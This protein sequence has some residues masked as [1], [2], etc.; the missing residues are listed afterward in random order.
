M[1]GFSS[2]QKGDVAEYRVISELLK[3]G[4]NVLRP[5]GDRLPYDLAVE[6]EGKI[7]RLQVKMAWADRTGNFVVDIRRSQTNRRLFKHTKYA[8]SDFEFLVAWIPEPEVFYIFPSDFACSFGGNISMVEGQRRQRPPR[9]AP[10]RNRWDLL[11]REKPSAE[12]AE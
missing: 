11:H 2:K 12:V 6:Y 7:I 9:S 10:Y 1:E 8:A 4:F 3:R 5:L